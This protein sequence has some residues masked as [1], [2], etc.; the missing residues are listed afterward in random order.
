MNIPSFFNKLRKIPISLY[1]RGI[2]VQAAVATAI[3]LSI[4]SLSAILMFQGF[5]GMESSIMAATQVTAQHMSGSVSQSIRSTILPATTTLQLM[6]FSRLTMAKNLEERL[7][8]LPVLATSLESTP[9]SNAV[10]VGYDT[11][12]FILLR[13]FYENYAL[14]D[15]PAPPGTHY[16]LQSVTIGKDG[17]RIAQLSLY[18]SSLK[19]LRQRILDNYTFD[20]RVRPWYQNAMSSG[21]ISVTPPYIF[22]STGEIGVT[23]SQRSANQRAVIGFDATVSDLSG[24][25]KTLRVTPESEVAIFD[26]I[27]EKV[28]AYPDISRL[29]IADGKSYH[30]PT[31]SALNIPVLEHLKSS[32]LSENTLSSFFDGTQNWYIVWSR[33]EFDNN[34]LK[35]LIAIP[36]DELLVGAW[37]NVF[38]QGII[39]SIIIAVLLV[40]SWILGR[41]IVKPL[42]KLTGQVQSFSKFNFSTQI[43]V[44][45][46]LREVQEL[47]DVLSKMATAINGF[48]RMSLSINRESNLEHLLSVVL[49]Q[50]LDIVYL[51]YGGVYLFN[52]ATN[53]L[54]IAAHEG[55]EVVETIS[56]PPLPLSDDE[57]VS[58][59]RKE[60]GTNEVIVSILR[61]RENDLI[62]ILKIRC[63]NFEI[64]SLPRSLIEFIDRI[65]SSAAVAIETRQLILT[66]KALLDGMIMLVADAIDTKSQHTGGHCLRVPELALM[67]MEVIQNSN[68]PPFNHFRMT[69]AQAE[70]FRIAAWLHDCG[71]I[72]TPEYVVDKATKLETINNRIHEIR[73]RFEV[74]HRDATIAC[75]KEIADGTPPDQAQKKCQETHEQL[76]EEFAFIARCNIGV[77][78]MNP[79]DIA[80]V[81]QHAQITWQRHFSDR[82]GLSRDELSRF[83]DMAETRLPVTET[84]LAD[85]ATH[86]IPWKDRIPPVQKDDP[87]NIWGFDMKLPQHMY[88]C[89]EIYN[90]CIRYGTLTEEERFKIND[91]I[92]QTI[93]ML[94]RLP[95]PSTLARVPDIAGNHHERMDGNGYPRK[96]NGSVMSIPEKVMAV[97]DIFEA[98]TAADRPYKEGKTLS[99]ALAIL[100]NMAKNGHVDPDV[101][102]L[103]LN[104]GVYLRYAH[105]YLPPHQ[106][107]V[108]TIE[109]YLVERKD[110]SSSSKET[111]DQ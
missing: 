11:G 61:N 90:L 38:Q 10:Y 108:T 94:S 1:K 52:A 70:E 109:S 44:D 86:I 30:L 17:E 96:L 100:S 66:Q 23:I 62:G 27:N 105:R 18:D 14:L 110:A 79:E 93:A 103:F 106:I 63:E 3:C 82:L 56:L 40:L 4:L 39:A 95:F 60:V 32:N 87:R 48:Q 71:K 46:K 107:D 28:V 59:I 97:A 19:L 81:Q 80:R 8:S 33:T 88:N 75:L 65:A 85:K 55:G 26:E 54:E 51:R 74:L 12:E 47:A 72:T 13:K 31:L 68:T 58:H 34:P 53:T 83:A 42:H 43:G 69:H 6:Q 102:N 36:S 99:Q 77:E 16:I 9:L 29:L 64:N 2:S 101:F 49:Q 91:H 20:P 22:F 73:T 50:L 41:Q 5:R 84:L 25:L 92:V 45:T 37:Q 24:L 67:M 57:I 35:I 104:S 76:A 78:S 15:A 21:S 98:L 111:A 89:G 7:A